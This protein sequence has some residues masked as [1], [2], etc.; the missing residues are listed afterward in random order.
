MFEIVDVTFAEADEAAKIYAERLRDSMRM[1]SPDAIV[2]GTARLHGL[3]VLTS[4]LKHFEGIEG[5][6][7]A[8]TTAALLI[9]EQEG[10]QP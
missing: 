4:N 10:S 2:A 5:L 7:V 9:D 1:I 8:A 3:P 6:R